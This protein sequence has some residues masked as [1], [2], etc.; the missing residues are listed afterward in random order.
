MVEDE[1]YLMQLI[2]YVHLNPVQAG[3]VGN[4]AEHELSGHREI[5]GLADFGLVARDQ[6]LTLYGDTEAEASH[7]YES[8]LAS[9]LGGDT[10]WLDSTP[11]HLP[12]WERQVD[13]P[14]KPPPLSAWVDSDGRPHREA[15]PRLSA[16]AFTEAACIQLGTSLD[17]VTETSRRRELTELRFLVI[18]LGIER[19]SQR[20]GE[21]A[22]VFGRRS[23]YVS[24]WAKRARELRLSDPAWA[25]K[26]ETLDEGMRRDLKEGES[27]P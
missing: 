12:W 4:P 17:H 8:A 9:A 7:H 21:L 1:R 16:L 24:W 10:N 14:L 18:G 11:G 6:V 26:Y 25:E 2:A 23:D 5:V 22:E 19:W 3:I 27:T 20:A 13:R 15:R